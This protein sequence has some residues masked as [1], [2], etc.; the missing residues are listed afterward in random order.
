MQTLLV[1]Q[2]VPCPAGPELIIGEAADTADKLRQALN[3]AGAF[4][5]AYVVARQRSI[6]LAPKN[7]WRF[8]ASAVLGE[9]DPFLERLRELQHISLA[10]L[11]FQRLERVEIGGS[12]VRT[13]QCNMR[14]SATPAM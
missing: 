12:R 7:Q 6:Q 4:R 3:V 9:F 10:A 8:A 11:L 14:M 13:P 1:S 2:P 5:A